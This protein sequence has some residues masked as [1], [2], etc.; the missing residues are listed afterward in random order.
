MM[1][2]LALHQMPK[3]LRFLASGAAFRYTMDE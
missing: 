2:N 1:H 3:T